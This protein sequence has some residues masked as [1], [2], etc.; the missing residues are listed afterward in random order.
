[1]DK[2]AHI[3]KN[4]D[5]WRQEMVASSIVFIFTRILSLN[6]GCFNGRHIFMRRY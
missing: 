2:A 3:V 6:D 5:K 4:A 1:M